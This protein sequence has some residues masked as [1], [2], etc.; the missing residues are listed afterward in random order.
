M[1]YTATSSNIYLY[2]KLGVC[3]GSIMYK[4]N[5]AL[6]MLRPKYELNMCTY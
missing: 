6:V 1:R 2:R 4:Y 5:Y 3:L